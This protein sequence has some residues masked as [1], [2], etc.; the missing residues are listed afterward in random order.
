MLDPE[1]SY[2]CV[3]TNSELLV[4]KE[5]AVDGRLRV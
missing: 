3:E 2:C 1:A 5:S 4:V